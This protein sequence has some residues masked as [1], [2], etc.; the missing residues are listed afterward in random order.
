MGLLEEHTFGLDLVA[1]IK[2]KERCKEL[3]VVR[4]DE[5]RRKKRK[6]M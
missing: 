3:R 2:S 6:E 4:H 5:K 1:L